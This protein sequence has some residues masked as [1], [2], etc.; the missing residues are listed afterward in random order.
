MH[1]FSV[2]TFAI[3]VAGYS[4]ARWDLVTRLHELAL[5]A[6]EHG[7]AS[8]VAKG[9]VLLTLFFCLV[10]LPFARLAV[11]EIRVH[12][13]AAPGAISAREQLKRRGSF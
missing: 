4:T 7:V 5:F 3:F 13:P 8:R 9:F 6:W 12:P 10:A 1:A 11:Y 2:L